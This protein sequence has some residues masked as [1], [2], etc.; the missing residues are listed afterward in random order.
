MVER[1]SPVTLRKAL[2]LANLFVKVGVNFVPVPVTND[3]EQR[4]LV[5][6][7]LKRLAEIEAASD[8]GE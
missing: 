3:E 1:A 7:A 6:K 2:E 8:D 5:E 4:E